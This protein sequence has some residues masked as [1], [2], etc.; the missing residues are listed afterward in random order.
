MVNNYLYTISNDALSVYNITN[1]PNPVFKNTI[2][3]GFA[4]QTIF[5]YQDKLFIGSNT[6]MFIYSLANP[7]SPTK[8]SSVTYFVRGKDPVVARDS[9]AYSTVRNDF[10]IGGV[11]NCFNIKD[12]TQPLLV[13]S[14]PM[15]NPYGMGLK[16]TALYAC[17]ADSGIKV[18]NIAN[19]YT[20]VLSTT[21]RFNETA[22]DIIVTGN[23]MVCYI[24][25][26]VSFFDV[27]NPMAPSFISS[28]KN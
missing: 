21:L 1:A 6:D 23:I 20:P 11:L 5:A 22:Y 28:I 2:H 27:A 15:F 16:G 19:P 25:G 14:I 3:I 7:E 12:I 17:E 26:G 9:F 18:F 24:K 4:I 8:L 10:G 13:S